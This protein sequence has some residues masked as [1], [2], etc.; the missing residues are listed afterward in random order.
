MACDDLLVEL[1]AARR[2]ALERLIVDTA[3]GIGHRSGSGLGMHLGGQSQ[4]GACGTGAGAQAI[5]QPPVG[6]PVGLHAARALLSGPDTGALSKASQA[7]TQ[8]P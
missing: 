3:P 2:L 7:R 4:H 1:E 8:A 5:E 6:P